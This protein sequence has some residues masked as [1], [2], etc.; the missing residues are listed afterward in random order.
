MTAT[1]LH[2]GGKTFSL[3]AVAPPLPVFIAEQP[4]MTSANGTPHTGAA[5]LLEWL[6]P[7]MGGVPLATVK[8]PS[9]RQMRVRASAIASAANVA[10]IRLSPA[11]RP[12]ARAAKGATA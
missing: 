3:R 5:T 9:G 12:A 8:L 7:V 4:C 2:I 11:T 6:D 1:L 10:A